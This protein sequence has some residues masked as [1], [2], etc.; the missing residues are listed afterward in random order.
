M[1]GSLCKYILMFGLK[2]AL[3]RTICCRKAILYMSLSILVALSLQIL[4]LFTILKCMLAKMG[5]FSN[6]IQLPQKKKKNYNLQMLFGVTS[7][8][9]FE[10]PSIYSH[11]QL[12]SKIFVI[13]LNVCKIHLHTNSLHYFLKC[14]STIWL[15]WSPVLKVQ[16][17]FLL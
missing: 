11:S 12:P 9:D 17:P 6:K 3:R 16:E 10:K 14:I 15:Q 4:F 2:G 13:S 1:I 7:L 5:G 8:K